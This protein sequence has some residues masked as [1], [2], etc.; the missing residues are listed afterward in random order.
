MLERVGSSS[1]VKDFR[2]H[3]EISLHQRACRSSIVSAIVLVVPT[4]ARATGR[5]CWSWKKMQTFDVGPND[6]HSSLP[7]LPFR[8]P[9]V[10]GKLQLL[11]DE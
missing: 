7:A 4:Y 1:V 2:H 8:D 9:D 11:L 6:L 3:A 5:D 10:L